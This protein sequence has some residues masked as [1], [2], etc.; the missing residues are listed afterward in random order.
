MNQKNQKSLKKP[1]GRCATGVAGLDDVLGGGLP[2]HRLYLLQ[3]NPGV[4]KTTLAL[5]YLL[6]GQRL[7]ETALYIS[8]SE[9][10]DE[11]LAVAESHGWNIDKLAILELSAIQEQLADNEQNT[12]FH[13]SEVELNKTT[14]VL[15]SEVERVK[16]AR[17]VFDSLSELRLLAETPLRYRRQILALKTFFAGRHSTVLLLDDCT[18][19]EGDLH[20]QSIVH[21]VV[22]LE[23]LPANYGAHRRRL[24]VTKMRGVKFRDGNHDYII[25]R[26]GIRLFPRLVAAQHHREFRQ[27]PVSSGLPEFDALLG[28]GLD[29]GTS[30]L[31]IGPAGTGKST[32]ALQHAVTAARRGEKTTVFSFDENVKTLQTRLRAIGLPIEEYLES[33]LINIQQIDPAEL[34]PGQFAHIVK[35]SVEQGAQMILIDSVNGYLNAMPDEQFLSL[36]LH[37]LLTYLSQQGV[38]SMLT[39]AQHG[40]IGAMETPVDITYLADTVIVLR[41]F[42]TAGTVKKAISVVKKRS[43]VHEDT[44]RE[45][46]IDSSGLRVG[47]PLTRFRGVL[48][49]TPSFEGKGG[50]MLPERNE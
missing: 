24:Q 39:V 8:L 9:T 34:A 25:E 15:T 17:V 16:P 20:L 46:K 23:K 4:G 7:G 48:S 41:Y 33:G 44:I 6:E 12:F 47:Q 40:L 32:L 35:E 30:T 49:G 26:G 13:P 27:E 45:Y 11:I 18:S 1:A 3:G 2:V 50:A 42:E 29:R 43:G 37:E 10:R 22:E 36:Q 19:E 31:F 14:K 38:V 28:G 5:Q 21:G